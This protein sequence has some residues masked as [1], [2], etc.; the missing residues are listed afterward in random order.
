[1]REWLVVIILRCLGT[2]A[3]MALAFFATYYTFTAVYRDELKKD[4]SI[5]GGG[6][7]L[8]ILTLPV[9]AFLGYWLGGKIARAIL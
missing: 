7:A 6:S 8:C 9:G 1:M 5:S 4:P 3:G 2:L